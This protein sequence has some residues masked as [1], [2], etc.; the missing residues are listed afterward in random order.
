MRIFF[1]KTVLHSLHNS[2]RLAL[3]AL[4]I[5][6]TVAYAE[7]PADWIDDGPSIDGDAKIQMSKTFTMQSGKFKATPESMLDKKDSISGNFL[8]GSYRYVYKKAEKDNG[9]LV[10]EMVSTEIMDCE[11]KFYGTLKQTK[12]YK[13]KVVSEKSTPLAQVQMMQT[14]MGT[15]DG[16]LC[17]LYVGKKPAATDRKGVTNPD[18]KPTMT[19][20][21]MDAKLDK[22]APTGTKK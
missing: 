7:S 3:I 5:T 16:Q 13:G 12:K 14:S 15:T 18:Y 8:V 22:Y 9:Q 19:K 11:N 21:D 4:S 17:A 2:A 20:E 6:C 1:K 10:D